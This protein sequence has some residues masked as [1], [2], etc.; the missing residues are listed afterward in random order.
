M[1]MCLL[2]PHDYCILH[3]WICSSAICCQTTH[4][5]PTA[6]N[7]IQMQETRITL[8]LP[9]SCLPV[10]SSSKS[11]FTQSRGETFCY[12]V[13]SDISTLDK[14]RFYSF[15]AATGVHHQTVWLVLKQTLN[16]SLSTYPPVWSVGHLQILSLLT[17]I[18]DLD[19]SVCPHPSFILSCA[20]LSLPPSLT[21]GWRSEIIWSSRSRCCLPVWS[22]CDINAVSS[23]MHWWM[24]SGCR[25]YTDGR[26]LNSM[27][28]P[29][30]PINNQYNTELIMSNS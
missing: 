9:K 16:H 28:L 7:N 30:K 25:G 3:V 29:I 15:D 12:D 14:I 4:L 1:C 10:F 26:T 19:S 20:H 18:S 21:R 2:I 24:G 23:R 5:A 8:T 6:L 27:E 17:R 22:N 13:L 11:L